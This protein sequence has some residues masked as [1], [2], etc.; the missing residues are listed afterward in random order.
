MIYLDY[1]C[2]N[3]NLKNSSQSKYQNTAI[4]IQQTTEETETATSL[5]LQPL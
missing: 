4:F 2:V 5:L 1:S 3:F